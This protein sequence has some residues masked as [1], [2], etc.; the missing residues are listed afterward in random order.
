MTDKT[1]GVSTDAHTLTALAMAVV[2]LEVK[3]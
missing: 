1:L 3:Q 2:E